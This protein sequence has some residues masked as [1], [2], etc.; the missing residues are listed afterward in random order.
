MSGKLGDISEADHKEDSLGM[1]FGIFFILLALLV[2]TVAAYE[3]DFSAWQVGGVHL[4]FLNTAIALT[5]A[6]IKALLVMLFFMHL[7]H[8]SKLTWVVAA[9]GFVWLTIMVTFT[10]S[11][12]LSRRMISENVSEPTP[13][14]V[15]IPSADLNH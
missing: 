15:T 5:I 8:A 1:Y 3:V 7:R 4:T 9:A 12:Y 14:V 13:V 2:A 6:G 10:F 11:D